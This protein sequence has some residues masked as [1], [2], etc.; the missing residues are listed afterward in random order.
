VS[1]LPFERD[2]AQSVSSDRTLAENLDSELGSV[3]A[4]PITRPDTVY[5]FGHLTWSPDVV[6]VVNDAYARLLG[7]R[8]R[9]LFDAVEA[10]LAEQD[11]FES[12]RLRQLPFFELVDEVRAA[13]RIQPGAENALQNTTVLLGSLEFALRPW[14]PRRGCN[15]TLERS[16]VLIHGR[17][18]EPHPN[19]PN[20]YI[21]IGSV[22]LWSAPDWRNF[23]SYWQSWVNLVSVSEAPLDISRADIA[24]HTQ[25]LTSDDLDQNRF[26]CRAEISAVYRKAELLSDL[27]KAHFADEYARKHGGVVGNIES[28]ITHVSSLSGVCE[29]TWYKGKVP[30]MISFGTRGR[31]YA[32]IY[33]KTKETVR[34]PVKAALFRE[35]WSKAGFDLHKDVFNV[36]FELSRSWLTSRDLEVEGRTISVSSLADFLEHYEYLIT[37]LL[38]GENTK[39]WLRMVDLTTTRIERAPTSR[40]WMLLREA[41]SL[42]TEISSRP[43]GEVM[44]RRTGGELVQK[45]IRIK[46]QMDLL[47]GRQPDE[48]CDMHSLL[49]SMAALLEK[50][51]NT[52]SRLSERA[53]N[54][55]YRSHYARGIVSPA[56]R[57]LSTEFAA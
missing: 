21:E 43:R 37:Y 30:Q 18:S 33:N 3:I 14:S 16:G 23:L 27:E 8:S 56:L 31:I 55:S 25:S 47:S 50:E 32:R 24:F 52:S 26:V 11:P 29:K 38:G 4:R 12:E 10:H 15:F 53:L 13:K 39:G 45:L 42:C 20:V 22:A 46:A 54:H 44:L 34:S 19:R 51:A 1:L 35:I 28:L 5:L 57:S 36:E 17:F 9:D 48:K 41:A 7:V 40:G 2:P 6:T 49:V